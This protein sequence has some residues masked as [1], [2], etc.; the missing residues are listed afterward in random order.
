[1]LR[2][3]CAASIATAQ[4]AIRDRTLSARLVRML[5]EISAYDSTNILAVVA[6]LSV[7]VLLVCSIP[8]FRATRVDPV[9]AMRN[10]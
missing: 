7:V 8:A 3:A 5:F 1:L 9:V 10:E 2:R 4:L 6:V